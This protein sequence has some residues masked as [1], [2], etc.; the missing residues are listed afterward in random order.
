MLTKLREPSAYDATCLIVV[1]WTDGADVRIHRPLMPESLGPARFLAEL[2][3][4][5]LNRTPADLHTEARS[6]LPKL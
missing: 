2:T 5:V 3:T 1:A 4:G 6:Q